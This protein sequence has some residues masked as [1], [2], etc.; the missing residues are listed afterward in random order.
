MI[1]NSCYSYKYVCSDGETLTKRKLRRNKPHSLKHT[2]VRLCSFSALA[3]EEKLRSI[4]FN[5]GF[6][7]RGPSSYNWAWRT[8]VMTLIV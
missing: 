3:D 4:F 2:E 8:H 6:I 1:P 7:V 5:H